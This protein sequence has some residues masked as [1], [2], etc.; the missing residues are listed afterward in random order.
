[1]Q[2]LSGAWWK[3]VGPGLVSRGVGVVPR[4]GLRDCF[5]QGSIWES[6]VWSCSRRGQT[7]S[8]LS[9]CHWSG[10]WHCRSPE[11]TLPLSSQCWLSFIFDSWRLLL[12]PQLRSDS[13]VSSSDHLINTKVL[14]TFSIVNDM[15]VDCFERFLCRTKPRRCEAEQS[16]V[17][18]TCPILP[19]SFLKACTGR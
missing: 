2:N 9:A 6:T 1:M 14:H 5:R 3:E 17:T 11:N 4:T 16:S 15:Y 13:E 12:F 8:E 10:T 7:W 19:G 18:L